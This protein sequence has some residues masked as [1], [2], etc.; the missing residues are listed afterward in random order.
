[1]NDDF[2]RCGK[3]TFDFAPS[4]FFTLMNKKGEPLYENSHPFFDKVVGHALWI[5]IWLTLT[6]FTH[7]LCDRLFM[8]FIFI[9][10][11]L[12]GCRLTTLLLNGGFRPLLFPP[13]WVKLT[14]S[15]QK[16]HGLELLQ[17]FNLHQHPGLLAN[18]ALIRYSRGDYQAAQTLA[19]QALILAPDHPH[20]T[21]LSL[22]VKMPHNPAVKR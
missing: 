9:H 17:K 4:G 22:F 20:L 6:L 12:L 13:L 3:Y 8:T 10:L 7:P 11:F 21:Q 14:R 2:T 16:G 19:N 18:L 1:M 15:L 5:A